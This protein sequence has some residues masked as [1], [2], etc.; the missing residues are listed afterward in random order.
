[1]ELPNEALRQ[2]KGYEAW[3]RGAEDYDLI[4]YL[5]CVGTAD[6]LV[7]MLELIKPELIHIDGH[8]FFK[9]KFSKD[10]YRQWSKKLATTRDI[11]RVM[12][13]IHVSSFVQGDEIT[14]EVAVHIA[15]KLAEIWSAI[16]APLGLVAEAYGDDLE[17]AQV[18]L[19]Q[20]NGIKQDGE[21]NK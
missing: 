18:A 13:H 9:H 7:A 10:V 8:L 3:R 4:D 16:F 11:Q 20:S 19:F 12:N 2:L 21:V 1:M 15:T 5:M 6:S 17:T 14:N